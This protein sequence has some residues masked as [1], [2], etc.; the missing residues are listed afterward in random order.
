MDKKR[1]NKIQKNN[2]KLNYKNKKEKFLEASR[3]FRQGLKERGISF[4]E[5]LKISSKIR[6]EIAG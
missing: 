3:L 4:S 5:F 1:T 2:E 6:D